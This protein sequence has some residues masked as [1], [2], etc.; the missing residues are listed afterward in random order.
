MCFM[1]LQKGMFTDS[2]MIYAV[3]RIKSARDTSRTD[4]QGVQRTVKVD[5]VTAVID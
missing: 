5:K 1:A 4:A 2:P 3:E